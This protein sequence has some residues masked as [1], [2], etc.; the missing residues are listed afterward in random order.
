MLVLCQLNQT[1]RKAG[2]LSCNGDTVPDS[3]TVVCKR[4]SGV[5]YLIISVCLIHTLTES[6]LPAPSSDSGNQKIERFCIAHLPQVANLQKTP[7]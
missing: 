5:T 6:K 1:E 7:L 4:N 3:C 2:H